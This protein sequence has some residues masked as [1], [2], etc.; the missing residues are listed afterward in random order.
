VVS[1][2]ISAT[3][4]TSF[5][6]RLGAA[7]ACAGRSGAD[8]VGAELGDAELGDAGLGDTELGDAETVGAETVG[9]SELSIVVTGLPFLVGDGAAFAGRHRSPTERTVKKSTA[10]PITI[11]NR[12]LIVRGFSSTVNPR[13]KERNLSG[14]V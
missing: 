2:A 1:S 9:A 5:A 10:V 7:A 3:H 4:A 13:F 12:N 8:L 6:L 14:Q 11:S